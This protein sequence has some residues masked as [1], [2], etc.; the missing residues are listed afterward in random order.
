MGENK[1]FILYFDIKNSRHK[2]YEHL[3]LDKNPQWS[4]DILPRLLFGHNL[5][6]LRDTPIT[7][8]IWP[9]KN[10]STFL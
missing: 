3:T 4:T 7:K 8:I 10:N 6:S 5:N 9:W 2:L 1:T